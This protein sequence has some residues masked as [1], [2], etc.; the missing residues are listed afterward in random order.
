MTKALC[1]FKISL[2]SSSIKIHLVFI[3]HKK[4]TTLC[5]HDF[6]KFKNFHVFLGLKAKTINALQY[7]FNLA[8]NAHLGKS[9]QCQVGVMAHAMHPNEEG[10][11]FAPLTKLSALFLHLVKC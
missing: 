6:S 7:I 8:H 9:L 10:D 5:F 4:K 11:I 1:S 3:F 2:I